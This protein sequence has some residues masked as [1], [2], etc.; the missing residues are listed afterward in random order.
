M[1]K[2]I[3]TSKYR[4]S[5]N[6]ETGE[7]ELEGINGN[8]DPFSLEFPSMLDIGIMGSCPNKC[9][10]CYQGDKVEPHMTL[11]LFKQIIDEAKDGTCQCALGGRGDP[12]LHPQFEEIIKYACENGVIPNYTT[13]G[14]GLTDEQ[15]ESSK[16]YCGAV[17]VSDYG[18][19]FTFSALNRLMD[20][21]V[22]TN[23]HLVFSAPNFMKSIAILDG[24]DAWSGRVNIEKLN[25]VIF[26]L[27]KPQGRGRD[28]EKWIPTDLMLE[29][30]SY[31]IALPK[32][33][34]KVGM[35]SCLVN[36]IM[37]FRKLNK[38]EQEY[39]DTCEGARMSCYIT[40]DGR[41]VPCSFG[42]HDEYGSDI[43]HH[44]IRRVWNDGL[45]FK[46]FRKTLRSRPNQCPFET[47]GWR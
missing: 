16:K 4:I 32:T 40:P 45:A 19:E 3:K 29:L 11:D 24:Q 25:A 9:K 37:R 7:E 8:D 23:I 34:F 43:K 14:N 26:L 44:G 1:I 12:N 21:E 39:V 2:E 47:D 30:F 33:K 35:D 5:F 31:G 18:K 36:H 10:M 6:T 22:K 42:N 15:I 46:G 20:A 28:L 17:A 13:S 27:F 38:L 41:L